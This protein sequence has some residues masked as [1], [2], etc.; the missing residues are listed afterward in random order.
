MKLWSCRADQCIHDTML[1]FRVH[2]CD[3]RSRGFGSWYFFLFSLEGFAFSSEINGS[4]PLE[5]K[6]EEKRAH[7]RNSWGKPVSKLLL[8][9]V[10]SA[11]SLPSN[12]V[13]VMFPCVELESALQQASMHWAYGVWSPQNSSASCCPRRDAA[14]TGVWDCTLSRSSEVPAQVCGSKNWR[15]LFLVLLLFQVI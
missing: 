13:S 2:L 10:H 7:E 4:L 11:M 8:H 15:G 14:G 1:G 12:H 3:R 5:V 9:W 6:E